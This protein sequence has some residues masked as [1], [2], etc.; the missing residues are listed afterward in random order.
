MDFVELEEEL[1]AAQNTIAELQAR[2]E[3][4]KQG[5]IEIEE[6]LDAAMDKLASFEGNS[7][8]SPDNGEVEELKK[9][10]AEKDRK[11]K[12]LE[13]ELNAAIESV[14]EME[15]ELEL[16]KALAG[17]MDDLKRKLDEA[18]VAPVAPLKP[19]PN[20]ERLALQGEIDRQK[21]EITKLKTQ[22]DEGNDSPSGS[23]RKPETRFSARTASGC[24]GGKRR[25]AN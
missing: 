2:T 5:R 22:I 12:D 23:I 20:E 18:Q 11:Q 24:R 6:E 16:A 21:D 1:A 15:A 8:T 7:A 9:L 14:N 19:L 13:K 10:L 17:E 25:D 4:E 3:A